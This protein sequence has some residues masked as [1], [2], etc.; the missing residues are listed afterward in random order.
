MPCSLL[1]SLLFWRWRGS[2]GRCLR[3]RGVEG[4]EDEAKVR[5]S[6]WTRR[7]GG[8]AAAVEV[9]VVVLVADVVV[10][11][12]NVAIALVDEKLAQFLLLAPALA[13]HETATE[14]MSRRSQ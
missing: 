1:L 11:F 9:D 13:R 14:S 6:G 2:R 8:V 12:V 3:E 5:P 10:D 4:A 7:E